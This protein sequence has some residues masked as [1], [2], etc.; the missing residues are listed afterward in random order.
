MTDG[1]NLRPHGMPQ[2][3]CPHT[4]NT[5]Q[6]T[7][8]SDPRALGGAGLIENRLI[9]GGGNRTISPNAMTAT[10]VVCVRLCGPLV[11]G[12]AWLGHGGALND[13]NAFSQLTSYITDTPSF[14]KQ[15]FYFYVRFYTA[16]F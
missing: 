10:K 1:S 2:M 13:L 8:L 5:N 14:F 4:A 11:A 15:G 6:P 9:S 16:R 12:M 3:S 7:R